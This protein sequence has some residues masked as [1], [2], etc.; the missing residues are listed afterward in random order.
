[1]ERKVAP[2]Q[3]KYRNDVFHFFIIGAKKKAV[4]F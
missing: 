2:E 3:D 4:E 1:M